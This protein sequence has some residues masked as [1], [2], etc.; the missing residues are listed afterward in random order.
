V[1]LIQEAAAAIAARQPH[2]LVDL[3][4]L[5]KGNR[6]GI[7]LRRPAPV[8]LTWLGYPATS[9]G[10]AELL[11]SDP[12]ASPPEMRSLFTETLLFLPTSYF[13]ADHAHLYP[14]PASS[15]HIAPRL[16]DRRNA[17]QCHQTE[18]QEDGTGDGACLDG[19]G[20]VLANFG[21]MYKIQPGVLDIWCR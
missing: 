12:V 13:L 20:A 9:G 6:P 19:D 5:S 3:N 2:V 4:G 17:L 11:A 21:Q 16:A 8:V 15:R 14:L 1:R 7:L 18:V 10:T